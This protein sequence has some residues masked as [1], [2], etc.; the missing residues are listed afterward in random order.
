MKT[1]AVGTYNRYRSKKMQGR[2][3]YARRINAGTKKCG[4]NNAR[5]KCPRNIRANE[6]LVTFWR[7]LWTYSKH[8]RNSFVTNGGCSV[9]R[10][11][12]DST[13]ERQPTLMKATTL[14]PRGYDSWLTA[15]FPKAK[16]PQQRRRRPIWHSSNSGL[17]RCLWSLKDNWWEDLSWSF[18]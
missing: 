6:W 13:D 12:H 8:I 16:R 17:H 5:H 11:W 2:Y 3:W 14:I 15:H 1:V 10:E 7:K 18:F 4:R 9:C